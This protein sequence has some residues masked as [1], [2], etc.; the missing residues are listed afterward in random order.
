MFLTTK[1]WSPYKR[2]PLIKGT[3]ELYG[4]FLLTRSQH[5]QISHSK[6]EG[7]EPAITGRLMIPLLSLLYGSS[8]LQA[9]PSS[10]TSA[11]L[12]RLHSASL[13]WRSMM[14]ATGESLNPQVGK[15][16]QTPSSC[17]ACN[18]VWFADWRSC[19]CKPY[20]KKQGRR[21]SGKHVP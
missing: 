2:K 16:L 18:L 17:G 13:S 21:V 19:S 12:S 9:T 8:L 11:P 10:R 14:L 7:P 1:V 3:R 15:R 6:G 5:T 4:N 20:G